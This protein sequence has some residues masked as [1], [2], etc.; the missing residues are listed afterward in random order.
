MIARSG[1]RKLIFISVVSTQ[2]LAGMRLSATALRAEAV[3]VIDWAKRLGWVAAVGVT[4]GTLGQPIE[5][6]IEGYTGKRLKRP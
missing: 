4:S 3:E 2:R 5:I 1:A 6:A